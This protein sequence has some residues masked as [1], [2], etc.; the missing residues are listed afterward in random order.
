MRF[1]SFRA[2]TMTETS[3][4]TSGVSRRG[5]FAGSVSIIPPDTHCDPIILTGSSA[6]EF[7]SVRG[8]WPYHAI[9]SHH[10][11]ETAPRD[12]RLESGKRHEPARLRACGAD[13]THDLSPARS[14]RSER[15]SDQL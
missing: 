13:P 15:W 10:E 4:R 8:Q 11:P 3:F 9:T 12:E 1:A 5:W 6:A 14:R 2:G 7:R